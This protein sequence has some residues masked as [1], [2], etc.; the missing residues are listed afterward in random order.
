MIWLVVA[1]MAVTA[2]GG[3]NKLDA[4]VSKAY[5][6]KVSHCK[7]DTDTSKL[8]NAFGSGSSDKVTI[9]DC[10]VPTGTGSGSKQDWETQQ[11]PLDQNGKVVSDDGSS[12]AVG[13]DGSVSGTQGP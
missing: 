7:Q 3:G 10:R 1:S 11:I 9:Y 13:P 8:A 6:S 4:K 5:G 12:D 2:C